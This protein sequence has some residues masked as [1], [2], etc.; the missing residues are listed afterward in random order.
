MPLWSTLWFWKA[1]YKYILLYLQINVIY[2]INYHSSLTDMSCLL[3]LFYFS[4]LCPSAAAPALNT[5]RSSNFCLVGSHKITLASLGHSK[6]P[7]DKVMFFVVS[8]TKGCSHRHLQG[9]ST[10]KMCKLLK[11]LLNSADE[12]RI[13]SWTTNH[14]NQSTGHLSEIFLHFDAVKKC[15]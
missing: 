6:F 1:L 8:A 11:S 13:V 10:Q 3:G 9:T 14:W 4:R 5:R 15:S 2:P 12:G 7:L